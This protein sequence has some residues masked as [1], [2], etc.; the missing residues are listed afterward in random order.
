MRNFPPRK[1]AYFTILHEKYTKS[2]GIIVHEKMRQFI[3]VIEKYTK[4][5]DNQNINGFTKV[6]EK[7]IF[8]CR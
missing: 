1:K 2:D 4:N 3:I 5:Y 8:I 6:H 7:P